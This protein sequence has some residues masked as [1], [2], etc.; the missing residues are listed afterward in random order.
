MCWHELNTA[1]VHLIICEHIKQNTAYVH[2]IVCEFT[3]SKHCIRP[4]YCMCGYVN[5]TL[6]TSALS[7]V[8][9][10]E[11]NTH[12]SGADLCATLFT[13]VPPNCPLSLTTENEPLAYWNYLYE[14]RILFGRNCIQ[15]KVHIQ[16]C[17][18]RILFAC[19][20]WH[21]EGCQNSKTGEKSRDLRELAFLGWY[22]PNTFHVWYVT[23]KAQ[24]SS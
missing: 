24:N 9:L 12:Y 19:L 1:Y 4:P 10:R 15:T 23:W 16:V 6:H 13:T 3:W 5:K 22:H 14:F 8:W 20:V 21:T 17:L 2:F 7:Y 11:Q 18:P